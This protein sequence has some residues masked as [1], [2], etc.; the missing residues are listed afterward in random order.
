MAGWLSSAEEPKDAKTCRFVLPQSNI[1]DCVTAV[2]DSAFPKT[3]RLRKRPEFVLLASA[4]RKTTVRGF[5]MV[6]RK[7]ELQL[8][9]LGI[10]ASKKVGCAVVRN[11]IKR[12]LR[13]FFR[14]NRF[15]MAAVDVNVIVR[16]ES[17]EMT[18]SEIVRELNS[19]FRQIGT[20]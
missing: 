11:R 19:A 2:V 17:V 9:R 7:N 8:A 3:A 1:T 4:S 16:R 18:Y 13:E 10:T 5:L 6:W 20:S 14:Q 12:Y 15:G